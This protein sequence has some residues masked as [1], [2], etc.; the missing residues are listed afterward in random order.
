M[1]RSILPLLL[2]LILVACNVE[3]RKEIDFK[4]WGNYWFQGKAEI[5]S[6]QLSQHRYGESR[7]GQ[8]VLI[9]VTEDFSRKKHVKLDNPDEAGKDKISVL[10]MNQT[11]DFITGIYP[12]HMMLS[13]FTPTKEASQGLK[14]T[15]SV[16]EWCG[17]TFTQ[18]NLSKKDSYKGKLYS[19]FEK[20]GDQSINIQGLMEDELWN[21]LRINPN[22]IPLGSARIIPSLFDQRFNHQPF[23]SEEAF[24][25]IKDI[26][27]RRSQL[28]VIYAKGFR[29]LRIDFEKTFPFHIMGWEE[30]TIRSNGQQEKTTATRLAVSTI[31]YW[32][33]NKIEDEY[34]RQELRLQ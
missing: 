7:A 24:I 25:S 5:S 3:Q 1:K 16:Q 32:K 8:A 17:Q 15:A 13:A 14:F 10:K 9:F 30:V 22:Q 23:A 21:L 28:E 6:F 29:E 12:Y 18:F 11:R 31:D 2:L 26:S 19:Y 20:E 27:E 33:H 4:E 34:L